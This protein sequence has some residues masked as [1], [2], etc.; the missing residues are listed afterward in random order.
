MSQ[1]AIELKGADRGRFVSTWFAW[2]VAAQCAVGLLV[3][4]P[5]SGLDYG[6]DH[7]ERRR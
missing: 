7:S 2:R 3:G 1:Q 6:P 4:G 5:G